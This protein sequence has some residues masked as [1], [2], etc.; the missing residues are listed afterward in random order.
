MAVLSLAVKITTLRIMVTK[1]RKNAV[2]SISFSILFLC[3]PAFSQTYYPLERGNRW[4]YGYY[5][6]PQEIQ[7]SYSVSISGDTMMQNGF[8]YAVEQSPETGIIFLRQQGAQV[9]QYGASGGD[10]ILYDFSYGYLWGETLSVSYQGIDTL[11]TTVNSHHSAV[12]DA[13]R[14]IWTYYTYATNRSYYR[15]VKIADSIGCFEINE[16]NRPSLY[17]MGAVLNGKRYGTALTGVHD[18][19]A[20]PQQF[21]LYQNYPNPFNPTT[22]ILYDVPERSY[23]TIQVFNMLG[24][25]M[26]LLV[27]EEKGPGNYSV[28]F[29]AGAF[30]SGVYVYRMTVGRY[31]EGKSMVIIR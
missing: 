14:T 8:P 20:R 21:V 9:Y 25:G 26:G 5:S 18:R 10:S 1:A 27:S 31:S 24:Q 4:D 30:P 15:E 2:T 6:S 13:Q 28:V 7:Y 11:I 23:V 17:L 3:L 22:T 12:F 29:N 16:S 19:P